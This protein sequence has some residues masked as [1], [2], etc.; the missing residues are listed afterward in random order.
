MATLLEIRKQK[1]RKLSR[2]AGVRGEMGWGSV[3]TERKENK[4]FIIYH[5]YYN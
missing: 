1:A 4:A 2:G 5:F 3:F